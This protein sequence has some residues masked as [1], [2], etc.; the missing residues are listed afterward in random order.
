[1]LVRCTCIIGIVSKWLGTV[2]GSLLVMIGSLERVK[3]EKMLE[4]KLISGGC[5]S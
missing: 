4:L 5:L 1:M 2:D 3:L